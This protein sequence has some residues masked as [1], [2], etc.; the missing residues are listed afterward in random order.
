MMLYKRENGEKEPQIK[1]KMN[2]INQG[3]VEV[4]T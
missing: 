1:Y 4:C 3:K 2:K